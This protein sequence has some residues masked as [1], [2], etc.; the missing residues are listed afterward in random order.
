MQQWTALK[1]EIERE[2][3]QNLFTLL[4]RDLLLLLSFAELEVISSD[5][6][7]HNVVVSSI[8]IFISWV[9]PLQPV[10]MNI[11]NKD[12]YFFHSMIYHN[13]FANFDGKILNFSV[14]LSSWADKKT[15]LV[16]FE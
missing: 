7:T 11:Q 2:F 16:S 9:Y 1:K 4:S 3:Y 10:D 13:H 12:L 15:A 8:F 6:S 5:S 14:L